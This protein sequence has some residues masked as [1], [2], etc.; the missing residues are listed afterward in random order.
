M[1]GRRVPD[2]EVQVSAHFCWSN[3]ELIVNF[4]AKN[5][6]DSSKQYYEPRLF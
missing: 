5:D 2:S 3:L 1:R 6:N 4:R